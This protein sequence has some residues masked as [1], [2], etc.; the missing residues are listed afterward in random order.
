MQPESTQA[1]LAILEL[2]VDNHPGVMSH[3]C[4]LF[5]RRA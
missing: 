3:V 2:T 5:S 1:D 4:G